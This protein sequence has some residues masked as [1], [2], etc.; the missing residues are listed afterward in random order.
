VTKRWALGLQRG[1][2]DKVL[3]GRETGIIK[4]MPDGE[5]VEVHQPLSQEQL[6]LLTQHEQYRPIDP[7]TA[8]G[9]ANPNTVFRLARQ[10]RARLSKSLYGEGAQ[11]TKPTVQEYKDKKTPVKG[12][13]R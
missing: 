3:H 7:G 12:I 13:H 10:L 5:F 4:R 1:D 8:N 6:H 9:A 11:I 2:R